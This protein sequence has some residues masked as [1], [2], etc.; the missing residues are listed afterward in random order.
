[1]PE[2]TEPPGTD[3]IKEGTTTTIEEALVITENRKPARGGGSVEEGGRCA[4]ERFGESG[5][6][7]LSSIDSSPEIASLAGRVSSLELQA[8][9]L[10]SAVMPAHYLAMDAVEAMLPPDRPLDC[11]VCD[12]VTPRDRL[13]IRTDE[14]MFGGGRL[15]RYICPACGCG[16]GPSK[17]TAA[18]D[19]LLSA[20]YALLYEDYKEGDGT[21]TE[22][23]A[24]DLLAHPRDLPALNWGCGRW[25]RTIPNLRAEG[26]DVWGYDPSAGPAGPAEGSDFVVSHRGSISPVFG[27]AFSNNVIEHMVRPV[28]EFRFL[29]SILRP[30]GRMLHASPCHEWLYA[31]SRYHVFFPL[32][33]APR[34]LAER[35]GFRAVERHAD[36]EF[37]AWVYERV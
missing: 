35:T 31:Q 29:H 26:Y 16:F 4:V 25:S 22:R 2:I 8:R 13:E 32:G 28:E 10:R 12:R 21:R 20:D 36:G 19:A 6:A 1:M 18:P 33:D 9:H 37:I 30:G 17:V 3:P 15:E 14:D 5:D 24:F 11:P 27:G 34:V 23:R 7:I